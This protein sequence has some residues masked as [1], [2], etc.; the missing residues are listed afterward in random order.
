MAN[1]TL[2]WQA[3]GNGKMFDAKLGSDSYMNKRTICV[4]NYIQQNPKTTQKKFEL[5]IKDFLVNCANYNKNNSLA[6]HFFRPL[7]FMGF[8]QQYKDSRLELTIEGLKF[9]NAYKNQDYRKC[10]L[11]IL[12]QLDNTKYPNNATQDI[13]LNLFPFRILFKILLENNEN[14]IS[15]NFINEQLVYIKEINDLISYIKNK[16]FEYI[17]KNEPYDKFY[18]WVINSLLN[19]EILKKVESNY[20]IADDLIEDI[21]TL[22]ANLEFQDFFFSDE[23]IS[24]EINNKTA[25]ERY[26][27]NPKLI[28]EAKNRDNFQCQINHQHITFI[29]N[30]KNYVEGHHIIP[31]FQQK[32][33][34]FNL[35]DVENIISLCPNCHREIHS[36]DDK[37]KIL[38]NLYKLNKKY[39]QL[40]NIEEN[41]F[42]KMYMCI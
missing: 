14:G 16:N 7:L 22:Y 28:S 38:D 12:N 39:M 21:K 42:Y 2:R 40:N 26:K 27:R 34:E 29:S 23:T 35:D 30:E 19:I 15:P 24:C 18:T 31:M 13:K 33:Y 36:A 9:L 37:S 1:N 17:Q 20:F 3:P 11:Y 25:K 41:D 5:D 32:N 4:L 8:I 6:S 10:K